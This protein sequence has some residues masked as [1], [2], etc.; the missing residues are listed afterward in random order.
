MHGWY[1]EGGVATRQEVLQHGRGLV[2]GPG[3]ARR[4]SLTSR[5]WEVSA[6]RSTRPLA[7]GERAKIW[8]IPSSFEARVN[9]VASAAV[10]GAAGQRGGTVSAIRCQH[11]PVVSFAHPQQLGGLDSGHLVFQNGVEHGF[12]HVLFGST[13]RPS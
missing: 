2:H 8:R 6:I 5:Y 7:W 9:W 12:G 3:S 13:L 10:S 1:G 11:P 4:S